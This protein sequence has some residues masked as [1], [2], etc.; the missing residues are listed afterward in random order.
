MKRPTLERHTMS[1]QDFW[2][3]G[4]RRTREAF[5]GS[6]EQAKKTRTGEFRGK[7]G[8]VSSGGKR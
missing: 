7:K 4:G 8:N 6:E 2:G 3:G 1:L 5:S